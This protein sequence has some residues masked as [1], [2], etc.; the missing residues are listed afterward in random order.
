MHRKISTSYKPEVPNLCYSPSKAS[1]LSLA[2]K[3]AKFE[4]VL[5][6]H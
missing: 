3:L 1:Q 2:E 5:D 6:S 4:M